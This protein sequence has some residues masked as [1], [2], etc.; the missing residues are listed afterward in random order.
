MYNFIG[1]LAI[2][3]WSFVTSAVMFGILKFFKCLRVTEDEEIEGLDISKH[4]EA[5]Y[6]AVAWNDC[7]DDCPLGKIRCKN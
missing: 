6:P 4:E 2:F 7:G 1:L 5:A 3:L